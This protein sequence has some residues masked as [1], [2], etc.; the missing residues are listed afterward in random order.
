MNHTLSSYR[1]ELLALARSDATERNPL[2]VLLLRA[3]CQATQV[4]DWDKDKAL[5]STLLAA[6]QELKSGTTWDNL[7]SGTRAVYSA[8]DWSKVK[9]EAALA[10]R[11]RP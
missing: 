10:E 4:V 9:W 2:F 11:F 6:P 3:A 8:H 7:P 1:S 5:A